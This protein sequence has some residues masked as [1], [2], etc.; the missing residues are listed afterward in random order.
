AYDQQPA[1][2]QWNVSALAKALLPL[3]PRDQAVAAFDAYVPAWEEAY[4]SVR[5]GKL[6]LETTRA[7]DGRLLDELLTLMQAARADWTT[8]WRR[9]GSVAKEGDHDETAFASQFTDRN[10]CDAWLAR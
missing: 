5:R 2:G 8:V 9:L 7:D 3:M 10:G 6:G 1:I 4:A